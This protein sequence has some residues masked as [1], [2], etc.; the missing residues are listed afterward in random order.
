MSLNIA[1]VDD[2]ALERTML[3]DFICKYCTEHRIAAN[4][5]HFT[6]GEELLADFVA[7]KFDIIFLDIYMS[8]L[9]GI[10]TAKQLRKID[11]ACRLVFVT[12]SDQHAVQG[13]RVRA[14]DY[15]LKPYAFM[16]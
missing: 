10:D 13:F 11:T 4:L 3:A 9:N 16:R 6:N 5:I 8:G 7:Q 12:N 2:L 15:L 1:V 14:F